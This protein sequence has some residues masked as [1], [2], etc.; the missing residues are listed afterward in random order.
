[1]TFQIKAFHELTL[2]QL[3]K[4]LQ[5]RTQV[6]VVEQNCPYPEVDGKDE[7]SM[8]VFQ[9]IEGEI[10]A[11]C[12]L[13]PPGVS[14]EEASIGRVLVHES[15][16]GKGIAYEMMQVAI[17]YMEEVFQQS[18]IKIQAQAYLEAFYGSL[19]FQTIS[20]VYLE[21]NIPHID[22]RRKK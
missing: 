15:Y 5:Q 19:G 12:R 9:E 10:V 6:F 7:K 2:Q 13:L 4:I 1:M 18:I 16:R 11:Y 3:Y 21:D 14:Y 17:T 8:H 22:M 20:D